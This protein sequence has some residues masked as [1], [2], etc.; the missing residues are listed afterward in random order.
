MWANFL[1]PCILSTGNEGSQTLFEPIFLMDILQ[2][3]LSSVADL[4]DES[5]ICNELPLMSA[6]EKARRHYLP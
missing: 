3:W 4:S 6:V 1:F 5:Y 2:Y